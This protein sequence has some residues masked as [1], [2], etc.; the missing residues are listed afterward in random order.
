MS[1]SL[2]K[3][4]KADLLSEI[5]KRIADDEEQTKHESNCDLV[6]SVPVF[7]SSEDRRIITG[8]V[9]EPDTVDAQDDTISSEVI[10][11]AAHDF[12]SRYN[13]STQLGEQ[14]T[15]FGVGVNLVESYIAPSDLTIGTESVK[16][17]SW[18]LS[19][20][21]EDDEIWRKVKE[22]EITGFSIGGTALV[23]KLTEDDQED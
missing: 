23:E 11:K 10:E 2:E 20:H 16:K 13:L 5:A 9:L 4:S 7:K 15:F 3:A 6:I 8:I 18:I 12:L 21:V 19:V 1:V 17:G 22:G 14:H